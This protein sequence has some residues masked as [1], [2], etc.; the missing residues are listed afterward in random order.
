MKNYFLSFLTLITSITC[1]GQSNSKIDSLK[2]ELSST[3]DEV[4][5][6]QTRIQLAQEYFTLFDLE[7]AE[8]EAMDAYYVFENKKIDSSR[9]KAAKTIGIISIYQN[10]ID[11]AL[12][13]L[14]I[15]SQLA[16]QLADS[17]LISTNY[18]LKSNV[19]NQILNEPDKAFIYMDSAEMYYTKDQ[20]KQQVFG[21]NVK[22]SIFVNISAYD[23]ALQEYYAGLDLAKSDSSLS[24]SL[25]NNIGT[26]LKDIGDYKSARENYQKSIDY[27][28]GD[29]RHIGIANVNLSI[30]YRMEE[31]PEKALEHAKTAI[32]LLEKK[33]LAG[34]VFQV[35][36]TAC[37]ILTD[38]N[39]ISEAHE[40]FESI[41]TNS[42]NLQE[43][44]QWYSVGTIIE[45]SG[46]NYP[47]LDRQFRAN[48]SVI[49]DQV[50]IELT[51]MLYDYF[52]VQNNT[53]KALYYKEIYA[54]LKDASL[55]KEKII[56]TQ[57]IA[58]NRIVREKNEAIQAE[59]QRNVQLSHDLILEEERSVR[60]R[61][62]YGFSGLFLL[63]GLYVLYYRNKNNKEKLVARQNELNKEKQQRTMLLSRLAEAKT[64]IAANEEEL[65]SLRTEGEKQDSAEALM[66]NLNDRN[67]PNFLTEF[68]LVYPSFFVRL[69][70]ITTGSLSKNERRLCCLIK[71]NLSN[72]EIAEYVFVSP[73]SVKKAKNR[74]FKKITVNQ[75]SNSDSDTI[76]N[77]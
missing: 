60:W 37:Q 54:D 50:K 12:D 45:Y 8:K 57:R 70:A 43:R 52:K 73:E 15:S 64:A 9:A 25:Y 28:G 75:G 63:I 49:S 77:L 72:K 66:E 69:E 1:F 35:K 44:L 20:I 4:R 34:D 3:N 14:S 22:G 11:K 46:F 48:E 53:S 29:P 5:M 31:K 51:Q 13:Y 47:E 59:E 42:I 33:S 18:S 58:V 21:K 7:S 55:A 2:R 36:L 40:M 61:Y 62:I 76:R 68:E 16:I 6:A 38:L 39:R 41:D 24:A 17:A 10:R 65:K 67:W 56:A 74:L 27:A 32:E 71:L 30:V 19:Y 26:V 23:L